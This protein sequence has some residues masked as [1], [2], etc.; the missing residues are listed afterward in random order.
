MQIK[1]EIDLMM[2]IMQLFSEK[3]KAQ[4]VLRG[5]MALYLLNSKR[6]TNDL[7]YAFI[8][9][10]SKNEIVSPILQVLKKIENL[11]IAHTLNSQCLRISVDHK[12][13]RSQIEI[14]TYQS[15][16]SLAVTSNAIE[17]P[18]N[19]HFIVRIAS[20]EWS[21]SNKLAAWWE[22]RL[23]RD[24]YDIYF[25][26]ALL[27]VKP[28]ISVLKKR[29]LKISYSKNIKKQ[30]ASLTLD[31]FSILARNEIDLLAEQ[32]FLNEMRD[33]F[34]KQELVGVFLKVKLAMNQIC[35]YIVD[36]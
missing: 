24:L 29:L 8:P 2:V 33:Y 18:N 13:I 17:N 20:L 15:I 27:N 16:P 14:K 31:Q 30:A 19:P 28:D 22:R 10:K 34:N 26:F 5:G 9:Y 1:N 7:D 12:G 4:A 23:A 11:V 35:E 32:A 3:F 36:R 25:I 6:F 21:L